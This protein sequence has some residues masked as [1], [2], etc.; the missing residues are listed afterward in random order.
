MNSCVTDVIY[1]NLIFSPFRQSFAD[2]CQVKMFIFQKK[3][4]T[5]K[6]QEN[7]GSRLKI[8]LEN[9]SIHCYHHLVADYVGWEKSMWLTVHVFFGLMSIAIISNAWIGFSENPLVTKLDDT[10]FASANVP[11]PAVTLCSNNRISEKKIESLAQEFAA[12]D[13]LRRDREF[14]LNKFHLLGALYNADTFEKTDLDEFQSILSQ[15]ES[16]PRAIENLMHD[17][18]PKCESRI[19]RCFWRSKE[20]KC[21]ESFIMKKTQYGFCCSFNR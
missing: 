2:P 10:L 14:F 3:S 19:Q 16:S 7:F 13:Q 9:V 11:F 8:F 17:L 5:E 12:R 4:S 21:D 1:I 15:N 20:I 6:L 18:T